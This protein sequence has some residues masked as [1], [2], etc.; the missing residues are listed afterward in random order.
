MAHR[1]AVIDGDGVEFLGHAAGRLDFARDHLAQVFQMHVAGDE[2][3]ERVNHGND[4]LV[5]VAIFHAGGTPKG[6]R[7]GH[8]AAVGRGT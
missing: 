6:A 1:N 5:E 2:L 4:G 3:R 7:A 8:V